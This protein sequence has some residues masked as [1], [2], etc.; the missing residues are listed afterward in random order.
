M[1]SELIRKTI[2]LSSIGIPLIYGLAGREVMLWL[3]IPA[4]VITVIVEILRLNSPAIEARVRTMF[5]G[6]MREHELA[7]THRKISGA[8]WVL[9]S[10]TFCVI[11]FPTMITIAGFTILIVSDTAA[12]LIGRRFGRNRFNG[13][14]LE[15]SLAFFLTAIAVVAIVMGLYDAPLVFLT[16]G[17][18]A[19]FIA[20]AAEA[21]S[22]GANF[23]DNLTIPMSFGF[24]Q[25]GLLAFLGG[26]DVE[27]IMHAGRSMLG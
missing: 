18:V 2:H 22:H 17:I 10:A 16:T 23:D 4:T 8:A 1:K 13:K 14:S 24:A 19:A 5:G 25:W 26:P 12:A 3:L 21:F 7:E 6:I 9:L 20:T 15:G 11:V 27:R